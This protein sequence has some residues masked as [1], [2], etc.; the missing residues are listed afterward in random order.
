M[1]GESI[2]IIE[3]DATLLRGLKDNF[4]LRGYNVRTACDGELGLEAALSLKPDLVLLDIMLPK[5]NGFEICRQIREAELDMPII[6][7]T[8]KGQ[9]EDIVRGLNLGA[10][11]YMTKPFSVKELLARA[12]S[13]LRR[14]KSSAPETYAFGDC[15]LDLRSH[16]L[17]RNDEELALSPKEFRLLELFVRHSGRALTRDEI[18]N[19]VWGSDILVTSRSVDRC[20]TTLRSKIEPN[21]RQPR[22]I[23]TIRD[24]GYRFEPSQIEAETEADLDSQAGES[25]TLPVGTQLGPYSIRSLL[26]SGG[27]GDVYRAHDSRLARDVAIKVLPQHLARS[28]N[29][30]TRFKRETKAVAALSHATILAIYDVG[31]DQ[32][33]TYAVMELLEGETLQERLKRGSL[34]WRQTVRVGIAIAEGLS[35]AHAKEIVHRDVK[36]SNIFLT[37]DGVVKILDFGLAQVEAAAS[38]ATSPE[39]STLTLRTEPGAILGTAGYMSPEQIRGL[40]TDARSDIFSLGCVI[41]EMITGKG[42]F[43]RPTAADSLAAALK[44]EPDLSCLPQEV[45]PELL[46]IVAHGL[47]PDPD[48]RFQSAQDLGFALE[49]IDLT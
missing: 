43:A 3:D 7:L 46:R 49:G 4:V 26:G 44:D 40:P 5:L 8:A 17:F 30:L 37:G 20:I 42:P 35:A 16:R 11:D 10:D 32:D 48:R 23:Q 19:S 12:A 29:A 33:R 38:P 27:M 6:M 15:R 31:T 45:P 25:R 34:D 47:E 28:S 36:P 9:E 22:L 24:V 2:L 39:A 21:Q 18:M 1:A 14:R 13:F 41:Y